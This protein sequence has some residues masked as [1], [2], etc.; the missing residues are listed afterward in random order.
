MTMHVDTLL[1]Y[2]NLSFQGQSST[3]PS[4]QEW[5]TLKW[6]FQNWQ[7]FKH[8][9]GQ[10]KPCYM[11]KDSTNPAICSKTVQILLYVQGQYKPCYVF[12]DSTNPAMCSRTV[13]ILTLLCVQGQYKPCCVFK[14]N[15]NPAICSRTVQTLLCMSVFNSDKRQP[16]AVSTEL[17]D[18]PSEV[19][20]NHLPPAEALGFLMMLR[21]SWGDQQ[22]RLGRMSKI[23]WT[24]TRLFCTHKAQT[25]DIKIW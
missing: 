21:L 18:L 6:D 13:Q 24:S 2:H 7:T 4:F 5:K 10:Y 3:G 22:L 20:H 23:W 8:S 12:K 19:L 17:E 9:Q 25:L 14:D 15:T 16:S 11:F 1:G